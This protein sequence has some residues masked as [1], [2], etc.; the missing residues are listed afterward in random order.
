MRSI[1]PLGA[2]RVGDAQL[3]AAARTGD[4]EAYGELTARHSGSARR[5]AR[6]LVPSDEVEDLVAEAFA[7]VRLVLQRGDGP[8][9]AFRPYLLTAVR[10]L[11]V[12]HTADGTA[13]PGDPVAARAFT[14][15][16]E[17]WRM[18]LWHT[19]VE[20]ES[21]G[22]VA[23][24]L[25]EPT[26]S[27]PALVARARE[28]MRLAWLTMHGPTTDP[29][30]EWTRHNLGAYVRKVSFDR[31]TAR[32]ERHLEGC[33]QCSAVHRQLSDGTADLPGILA[34]LVL[35]SESA[36]YL[37]AKPESRPRL[38]PA[39]R[40]RRRARAGVGAAVAGVTGIFGRIGRVADDARHFV[41]TRTVATALAVVAAVAVIAAG[42]F[43]VVQTADGP[44]EASAD[45]P[46]GVDLDEPT[47]S[48]TPDQEPTEGTSGPTASGI[49]KAAS[50]T[51]SGRAS[52][53]PS[54]TGSAS[55]SDDVSDGPVVNP[56]QAPTGPG[57]PSP[58]S[59]GPTQQPPTQ[60]PTQQ[61]PTQQ[62]T[63]P[64]TQQQPTQPPTP[65]ADMG[66]TA[67]SS[68][69]LGL[70]FSVSARVTGLPADRS[71]TLVVT[72]TG[73]SET[74]LR[75]DSRCTRTAGGGATCPVTQSP[76]EYRFRAS[77]LGGRPNTI[78]FT[79]FPDGGADA[80]TGDNTASVT[81]G[82]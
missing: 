23:A 61:P 63:Q 18:V 52:D 20:G 13:A 47:P 19:E 59:Q 78:T 9:L 70:A 54:G 17:P 41:A 66:V 29:E 69:L 75:L 40:P 6:L 14:S 51:G 60:Q 72:S 34:P 65:P 43:I 32:V 46:I 80:D 26:D 50:A 2:S 24:L 62:P 42:T 28:G 21:P 55:P 3:I 79:V 57:R 53:D 76:A 10:R 8:D 81:L 48:D 5:L 45:A 68:S 58:P 27:V 36:G 71:G 15:L 16:A 44:L 1:F 30:C 73:G 74:G 7:K 39:R 64:P 33:E 82:G 37:S 4:A 22:E 77:A 67:S 31:D 49:G 56:T 25:G 11:H 38:R 12:D 35:G